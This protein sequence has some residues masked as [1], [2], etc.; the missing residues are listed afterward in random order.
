MP[1]TQLWHVRLNDTENEIDLKIE[2]EFIEVP[3]GQN[4]EADALANKALDQGKL[5]I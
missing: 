4:K 2:T 3:R 5:G 1:I